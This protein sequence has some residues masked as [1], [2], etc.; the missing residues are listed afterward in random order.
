MH[1]QLYRTQPDGVIWKKLTIDDKYINEQVWLFIHQTMFLS[2][3]VKKKILTSL[4]T[5]NVYWQ[6]S[7][8]RCF[9]QYCCC[10]QYC[11]CQFSALFINKFINKTSSTFYASNDVSRK[12]LL[13]VIIRLRNSCLITF[14]KSTEAATGG[15]LK[16]SCCLKFHKQFEAYFWSWFSGLRAT[17]RELRILNWHCWEMSRILSR[18]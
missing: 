12:K 17:L 2:G 13:H 9:K 15:A 4:M 16:R 5:L 14:Q 18:F 11:W 10:H 7:K 8:K 3:V 1:F 6:I